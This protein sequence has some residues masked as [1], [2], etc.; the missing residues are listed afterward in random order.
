MSPARAPAE[1]DEIAS[2]YD[3]TREPLQASEVDTI[4]RTLRGWGA[5]RLLEVGV[6]TGR[7]AGPLEA[8]GVEVIGVDASRGMLAQA[9]GKGLRSLVRGTAYRL[10]FADGSL[11]L[12]LFVH[13]LHLL[14]APA[15]ALREACR[16]GRQ[17]AAALVRP[18]GA[19]PEGTGPPLSA[20]RLLLERLRDQGY[21]IPERAA[22]GPPIRERALLQRFP[23]Q[24]LI[25]VSEADVV[26]PASSQLVQFERRASRWALRVPPE[27]LARA[28]AA[29]R[30]EIGDRTVSYHRVRALALW[31]RPPAT[32]AAGAVAAF[33][34]PLQS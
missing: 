6:G 34:R 17:G 9:R 24:Q 3:A 5:R 12:A 2:E 19:G 30:E 22:G 29:V 10:P 27:Q 25:T 32:E 1:F 4:A 20:R 11:D 33:E 21:P 26:E 16:V 7:V 14:D 23:P 28:V 13:V 18:A 15:E 31:D 8:L